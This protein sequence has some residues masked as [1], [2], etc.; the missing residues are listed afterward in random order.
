MKILLLSVL[1]LGLVLSGCSSKQDVEVEKKPVQNLLKEDKKVV[2]KV[3]EEKTAQTTK[4]TL[5]SIYFDFDKYNIKADMQ[6]IVSTNKD[7]ANEVL[8]KNDVKL[9]IEGNCDNRGSDEYNFALGL[10]RAQA[11]KKSLVEAGIDSRN[12][13]TK[14]LGESSPICTQNTKECWANNRRVDFIIK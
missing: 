8:R 5:E 12:I 4:V 13:I 14:S 2:E 1:T 7:K 11:V 10:K 6:N 3:L 9:T